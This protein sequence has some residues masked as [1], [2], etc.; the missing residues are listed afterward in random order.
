MIACSNGLEAVGALTVSFVAGCIVLAVYVVTREA[1]RDRRR[2]RTP[3]EQRTHTHRPR[4]DGPV[5]R[6]PSSRR[7]GV[8]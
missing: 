5:S 1:I 8:R 6:H 2:G 4:L 7:Q 3:A